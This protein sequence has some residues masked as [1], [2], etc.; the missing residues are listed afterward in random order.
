MLDWE[1]NIFL[2]LKSLYQRFKVRPAQRRREAL[3][4]LLKDRRQSLLL[5]AQ[6]L[7]GKPC[8]IFETDKSL[9]RDGD[10][11]FLP[12]AFASA[13]SPQSNE[14]FYVLKTILGSL[15]MR[16]AWQGSA[17]ELA[18]QALQWREEFPKLWQMVETL[19]TT[20]PNGLWQTLGPSK[21]EV[22]TN[23]QDQTSLALTI[24]P[25][26]LNSESV[27]EIEGK[28]Q[29]EVDVSLA[30]DEDGAGSEMPIHTFEKAE[31]LEEANGLSRKTDLDDELEDHAEAL[32]ELDMNQVWHSAERPR[33]IYRSDLILDGLSLQVADEAPGK[34][35]PYPEWDYQRRAYRQDWC[36][37][38]ETKLSKP[39]PAWAAELLTKHRSLIDRLRREFAAIISEWQ[40]LHRQPVGS[41]FDL[42]ALIRAEVQRRMGQVSSENLYI[43]KKR[44][45][46][47]VATVVLLD[48]SYSTDAWL[49]NRRVSDTI[50]STI[51]CAGEVFH[52]FLNHFAVAAFSSN[53]RRSCHFSILKE[54]TEP[55]PQARSRL[56]SLEPC[57]YTRIGP[58]L[59]HAQE[60]LMTHSAR[61]KLII[62]ITDGRPCDYDRYEG[63]YGIHDVKKAIDTG[64]QHGITTHAFAIEKQASE[65]FPRMFTKQHFDIINR[66]EALA[67]SLCRLFAKML[68]N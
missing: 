19:E 36:Y 23:E 15:A 51:F 8:R 37:I 11:L 47:D 48:Q 68:T 61:R 35:Q 46:H 30:P 27:T 45:L 3:Q 50:T 33:S 1:E 31:T 28:G 32:E 26:V 54:F 53:T 14:S 22:A 17:E 29:A 43:D 40:K 21:A 10:R 5:L 13:S 39:N 12:R 65:V 58:V 56:S 57:G 18:Q 49:E 59:R 55:W 34:G 24:E 25:T 41:E 66:P 44:D 7:A 6:M 42:D 52:D 38:Q 16:D 60:L 2:G 64:L 63:D 20:F 9:L 62:L 4:A 67:R